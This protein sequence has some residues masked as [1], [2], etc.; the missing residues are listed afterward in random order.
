MFVSLGFC[1]LIEPVEVYM[2]V[3]AVLLLTVLTQV[4]AR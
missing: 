2:H 1:V 3:A 4:D